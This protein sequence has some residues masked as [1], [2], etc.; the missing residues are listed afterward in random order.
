M[1]SR[2]LLALG[3]NHMHLDQFE[4]ARNVLDEALEVFSACFG[5]VHEETLAVFQNLGTVYALTGDFEGAEPV[6]RR[7]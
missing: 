2:L 6:L 7:A 3:L 1:T 4:D 5:E